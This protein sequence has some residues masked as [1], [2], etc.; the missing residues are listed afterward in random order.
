MSIKQK[1]IV[2]ETSLQGT[3]LHLGKVAKAV[4]K[5]GPVNSGILFVRV[6]LPGKPSVKADYKNINHQEVLLRCTSIRNGEAVVHT[7][8]HLMAVLYGLEIDNLIVEIDAEE[9]PG[10]DGSGQDYY[11]ALKRSGIVEQ[12]AEREFVDIKEPIFL[13]EGDCSLFATPASEFKI[14]Y[15]LDYNHPVL[16]AQ[17]F[18]QTIDSKTFEKEISSSRTFCLESEAKALQDQGLGKGANYTN[19]LVVTD[20]GVKDNHVRFSD[21]FVRHKVLDFIGDLY[22]LGKP[23]RGH[24]VGIKSGHRLNRRLL[25]KIVEQKEKY[26]TRFTPKDHDYTGVTA[27][28]IN[29]IRNILPHRYPFLFVDKVLE[30]NPGVRAVAVKNVTANEPF[31]QGHFPDKPVMPG[32]L[33]VEAMAQV[34]G[35]AVLTAPENKGKLALFMAIDNV[36][37][38]KVVEPGDQLV[39]EVDVL[40]CK[41][42]IAQ[43]KGVA[44]VDGKIA[45]EADLMFSF[46]D[47]AYLKL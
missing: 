16:S 6:D 22:L 27:L 4:F 30:L 36:K 3:G 24:I 7:V 35:I 39:F 25:Q 38:R 11:Q 2:H 15:T 10:M 31:F 13:E 33:M 46:T 47:V 21:E 23:V 42:R 14:S 40:K 5:P 44:K 28:D 43:V 41:S 1:T 32:V 29:G 37:F 20:K 19:T 45:V 26:E 12:E 34:G 17:F 8:E 9:L 18:N